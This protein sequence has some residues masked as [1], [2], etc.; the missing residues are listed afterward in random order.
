MTRTT[1]G[2]FHP[3]DPLGADE[4]TQAAA[5][6]AR[7]HGVGDGWRFASIELAEPAKADVAAFDTS[8]TVP[9]RR[10]IVVCFDRRK[11][12]T[13]RRTSRWTNGRRRTPSSAGT[14]T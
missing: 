2:T 11:N 5:V 8:G 4:F 3:L 9:D 10:A 14:R 1:T 12:E 6:L 13:Y 7:E